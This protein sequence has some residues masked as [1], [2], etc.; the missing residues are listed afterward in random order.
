M[1]YLI[2]ALLAP[3]AIVCGYLVYTYLYVAVATC[4][5]LP[6]VSAFYFGGCVN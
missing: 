5:L 4:Q 2:A 6:S 3:P 1:R